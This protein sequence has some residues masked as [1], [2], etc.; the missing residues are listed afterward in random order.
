VFEIASGKTTSVSAEHPEKVLIPMDATPGGMTMPVSAE[1]DS[2]ALLPMLVRL[3]GKVI[4]A[5][6]LQWLNAC[7]PIDVTFPGT[8]NSSMPESMNAQSPI[9]VMT[10]V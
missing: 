2:K 3:S 1:H 9:P 6:W 7:S 5:K 8:V 10:L 4:C